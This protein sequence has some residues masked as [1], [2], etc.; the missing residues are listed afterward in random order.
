MG[1][2][3]DP[4]P[5]PFFTLI[6]TSSDAQGILPDDDDDDDVYLRLQQGKGC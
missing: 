6:R 2:L 3:I 1:A 5:S 4:G